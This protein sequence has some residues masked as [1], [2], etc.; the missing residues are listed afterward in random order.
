MVRSLHLQG[1]GV[2]E[3][4]CFVVVAVDA[5]YFVGAVL[6]VDIVPAVT[7]HATFKLWPSCWCSPA[8]APPTTT[9]D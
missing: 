4:E 3:Q 2:V 7:K 5:E 1:V 8:A 6:D 9:T